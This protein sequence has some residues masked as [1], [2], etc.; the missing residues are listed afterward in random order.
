MAEEK[1]PVAGALG[2]LGIGGGR[3]SLRREDGSRKEIQV[4]RHSF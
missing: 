2:K 3:E 4:D 1:N